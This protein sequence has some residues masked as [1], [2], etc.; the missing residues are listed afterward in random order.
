VSLAEDI[1]VV[2]SVLL[3]L[4]LPVLV[5]FV[6]GAGVAFSF[7]MMPKVIR[8]FQNVGRRIRGLFGSAT[9]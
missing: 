9:A 4:F 3:A 6:I 5:F 1:L 2:I 7:W 8:F